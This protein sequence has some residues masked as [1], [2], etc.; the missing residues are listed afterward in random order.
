M[1][2]LVSAV[3]SFS[4]MLTTTP[5][6]ANAECLEAYQSREFSPLFVASF[7]IA[8]LIILTV[9]GVGAWSELGE[10]TKKI[11]LV[12]FIVCPTFCVIATL[13]CIGLVGIVVRIVTEIILG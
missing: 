1:K 10:E 5:A 9:G 4:L 2:N 11:K 12:R 6:F 8:I 13:T 3:L 7:V